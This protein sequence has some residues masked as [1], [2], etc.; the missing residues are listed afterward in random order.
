MELREDDAGR[1][2]MCDNIGGDV[3]NSSKS[4]FSSF[5]DLS[6]IARKNKVKNR[7][8]LNETSNNHASLRDPDGGSGRSGYSGFVRSLS[9]NA[10][11]FAA[12]LTFLL[13]VSTRTAFG[14]YHQTNGEWN[15]A[16]YYKREHSLS[17]PYQGLPN[18][19]NG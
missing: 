12:F 18:E 14:Q 13:L 8:N 6:I 15:T 11:M 5:S 2:L 19:L 3:G 10:I 1:R 4:G 17:K 16:D 7:Q 9:Y